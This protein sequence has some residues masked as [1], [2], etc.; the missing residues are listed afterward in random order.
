MD[1]ETYDRI[2]TQRLT[3]Q[4]LEARRQALAEQTVGPHGLEHVGVLKGVAYVNDSRSTFLD[5]S[6]NALASVEGP[7]LWIA[8][9][10]P[11]ELDRPLVHDFLKEK[12][13]ALIL[14]GPC[15]ER[16]MEAARAY[17]EQLFH[18]EEVRTAVFLAH[19]LA[20]EGQVVLFSP[21]CPSG[22]AFANYEERGAEFK[23]A[24]RDL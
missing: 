21:A 1:Q 18:A 12:V 9:A 19:E 3:E 4:L 22:E 10:W 13:V 6:L 8:G 20:R 2:L 17:T 15:T 7:V 24:V 23:R 5:A 14:F 11:T 16:P